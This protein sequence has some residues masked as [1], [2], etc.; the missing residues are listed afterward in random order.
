MKK[1]TTGVLAIVISSSFALVNAQEKKGD[2]LKTKE[3][4]E[5]LI[6][7]SL[8]IKKKQDA[9]TS[10]NKIVNAEELTKSGNPSAISA[11][12]GK[13]SGL[14]INLTN[15]SVDPSNRVVLRGGTSI[16]GN[17]QA[18]VVIDGAISSLGVFQALPP[19]VID[20][21]NVVKGMQGAALYGEKGSNGVIIVSTKRGSKSKKLKFNLTSSVDVAS[22]YKLPE[23]QTRYGQGWPGG[24]YTENGNAITYEGT[25][26]VPYENGSWGPSYDSPLGGQLVNIGM[27]QAD[28]QF[29]KGTYAPIDNHFSKFFKNG[30]LMQN[31]ISASVGGRDS[32]VYLSLDRTTNDFVVEGDELKRNNILLKAGKTMGNFSA[33][34]TINFIDKGTSTT[35]SSLYDDVLQ[36]PSNIDVSRFKDSNPDA[37]S[38]VYI[39]NP[40]WTSRNLR[41]DNSNK[42]FSGLLDLEYKINDHV[43]AKYTGNIV[44]SHSKSENHQNAFKYDR[45]YQ[46]TGSSVDGHTAQD[47]GRQNVVSQYYK[48]LGTSFRYYGDLML[49]LDYDLHSDLNMKLNLGHNIQDSESN[50]SQVGG[51]V[52]R[53]PGWYHIDNVINPANYSSLNNNSYH[54]RSFAWFANLDLDYKGYLFMNTTF[55]FEKSST[56]SV[57]PSDGSNSFKNDG[58][59]YYSVGFSFVPTKA[60]DNFK[61]DVLNYAKLSVSYSKVGNASAIGTYA[62][63]ETGYTPSGFPFGDLSSYIPSTFRVD[64][65]I[66]PEFITGLESTLNLGL[67]RDRITLEASVFKKSTDNLITSSN[68]SSATTITRLLSNI[69]DLENKGFEVDLGVDVVRSRDFKWNVSGSYS[70]YKSK[71]L[72]LAEGVPN[73]SLGSV[74]SAPA[75]GIYAEVGQEFPLIRGTKYLRDDQ[76][77]II[78]D[79]SGN[80]MAGSDF[81]ILGKVTPDYILGFNTS[82]SYKGFTLSATADYRTG[83]QFVPLVKR[84]LAFTGALGETAD[85]DR[86][87]GYVV[88]NSVQ[89]TGTSTNPVYVTNT[90]TVGND[91]SYAG[92]NA[93]FTGAYRKVGE[94]FV[95]DATALKIR[96]I[97]LSYSFPRSMLTSS[98]LSS[99]SIGVYARNPFAFYAKENKNFADPETANTSGNGAGIALTGQYPSI[100]NFGFN[101]NLT[102]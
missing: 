61:S 77:H 58:Y 56:L 47:F 19:E 90:T 40:Y 95:V 75:I 101:I 69:G 94:N 88:P 98:F 57:R 13:V 5:V 66:K 32:Y 78:V 14:Q 3:I 79:S 11:L 6:T 8:G 72:S 63:D 49:N 25:E 74:Y 62:I 55:R 100:R 24:G 1:L 54:S 12:N 50:N 67:F 71:V 85:F 31:G 93:Y 30:I 44:S 64:Q 36:T 10:A 27:P 68:V 96:E 52:L 2:T 28:G 51:T 22:V 99:A 4:K 20:N 48:S 9:I 43:S 76:G 82:M 7:G 41:Y 87:R 37:Y 29:L 89:N 17:N 53:I 35:S 92:T 80:P 33:D 45:V 83:H 38:S 18:L 42:V 39:Q 86:T 97:S 81:E 70:T 46:G 59:P 65:N 21:V 102:F 16:T 60:F 26:F 91:P 73:T 23:V 34:A 15:S 84:L